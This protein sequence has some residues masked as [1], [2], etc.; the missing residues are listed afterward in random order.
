M[1]FLKEIFSQRALTFEQFNAAVI[2][3]GFKL[4]NLSQGQYVDKQKFDNKVKEVKNI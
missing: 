2:E 3:K 1:E 4:A